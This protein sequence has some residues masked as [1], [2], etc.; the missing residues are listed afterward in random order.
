VI[1]IIILFCQEYVLETKNIV[2]VFNMVVKVNED[3][4]LDAFLRKH[5]SY[6]AEPMNNEGCV[7]VISP[8]EFH[9]L[10]N[11]VTTPIG[12]EVKEKK[13]VKQTTGE[14]KKECRSCGSKVCG[15]LA[16]ICGKWEPKT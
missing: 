1:A 14:V 11:K 7:I 10:K 13:P 6:L 5:T 2:G 8:K 12:E 16:G 3:I 15:M 4:D 9:L